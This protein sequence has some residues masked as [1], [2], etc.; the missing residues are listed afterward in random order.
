M[1]FIKGA[2]RF[3]GMKA[4]SPQALG[5][6]SLMFQSGSSS[7]LF[8]G[9]GDFTYKE[10]VTEGYKQLVWVYRCNRSI[11]E[12]V[13]S[14]PW[15]A[16][17]K[18]N[19][20]TET[21]LPGHPLEVLMEKPNPYYSRKEF[22][23]CWATTLG[24]AGESFWEVVYV[25]GVPF[26]LFPLRPDWMKIKPHPTNYI[27]RYE[28]DTGQGKPI[29][30]KPVHII[31]MKYVDPLNEYRGQSPLTAAARTVQTE[32]SAVKWNKT[33]LD[34]SAV[35]S[36]IL[37][38]PAQVLQVQQKAE[39][40][41]SLEDGFSGDELHKPMVLWGGM[42]WEQMGLNQKD[43]EFLAQ[44]NVNKYEICAIYGVPPQVIG[45]QEDPTYSNY[46]VARLS[47][48]EDNIMGMLEWIKSKVNT[49]LAPFF[50]DDIVIR[51][52]L[53]EVP[54]MRQAFGEKMEQAELLVKMGYPIN[55]VNERLRLGLPKVEWGDVAWMPATLQ[56][57][58]SAEAPVLDDTIPL[59]DP[60]DEPEE[61]PDDDEGVED[62][63]DGDE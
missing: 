26:Q 30:Y 38:V 61:D 44:R 19:D 6:V 4:G 62:P 60:D 49:R 33:I 48:W 34:N 36:G 27:D 29:K 52:D 23:E 12:A 16:Y 21:P 58:S 54:A 41:E 42:T 47:F 46:S 20:G 56:P 63:N 40:L 57:I 10:A 51:Y 1:N 18:A 45:A 43:M 53:S 35:P 17:K 9:K 11:G 59:P 25:A 31:H 37:N 50:G 13:A 5:P 2:Q 24:L 15:K 3:L 22:F 55:M 32:N 39:I 8:G 7:G 14:V 28:L